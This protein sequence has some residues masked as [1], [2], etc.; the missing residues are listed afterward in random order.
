MKTVLLFFILGI[1]DLAF[2]FHLDFPL[3]PDDV[4]WTGKTCAYELKAT[5][6]HKLKWKTYDLQNPDDLTKCFVKCASEYTGIY[7]P[8]TKTISKEALK[9]QFKGRGLGDPEKLELLDGATDGT[10]AGVFDKLTPFVIANVENYKNAFYADKDRVDAKKWY[11]DNHG[12]VKDFGQKASVFCGKKYSDDE[13]G[14]V[15]CAYQYYRLVDDANN[16]ITDRK[17]DAYNININNLKKCQKEAAQLNPSANDKCIYDLTTKTVSK[18]ALSKQFKS[19]GLGE[20]KNL[21]LLNGATDGKCAGVYAKLKPFL[22]A[23]MEN[24]KKAFY[25]DKDR[26]D[27]NKWYADNHGKVKD[28]GQKASV[29]CGEKYSSNACSRV[30]CAYQYYRLVDGASNIITVRHWNAYNINRVNLKECQKEAA[31][32]NPPANDKCK[33]AKA[34]KNCMKKKN[35]EEWGEFEKF[36]DEVSATN[37]YPAT[38]A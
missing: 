22:I 18:E 34:L 28:F 2:S 25:A 31:K 16:I 36:L 6:E 21:E 33:I 30:N 29:Y 13:C 4:R 23:N 17:W 11:A 19:R 1:A 3:D 32:I 8:T 37:E 14:K 9:K 26:V 15:N 35:K 10:C 5:P 7:D 38:S 12:K 24:Y 27:A 20:P